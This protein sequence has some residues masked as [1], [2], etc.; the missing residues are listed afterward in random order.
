[1]PGLARNGDRL[2][3]VNIYKDLRRDESLRSL[4][5]RSLELLHPS[6]PGR[7]LSLLRKMSS[8]RFR[9]SGLGICI[10]VAAG[11]IL[12][13]IEVLHVAQKKCNASVARNTFPA[14]IS[15]AG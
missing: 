12:S 9:G 10:P 2:I 15:L 13:D 6:S 3:F 11:K 5:A 8:C 1:M 7:S 14:R 4:C